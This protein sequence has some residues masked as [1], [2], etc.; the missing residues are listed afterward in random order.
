M[1]NSSCLQCAYTCWC[2]CLLTSVE[3]RGNFKDLSQST[4]TLIFSGDRISHWMGSLLTWLGWPT[5]ELLQPFSLYSFSAGVT[6]LG[7]LMWV[8]RIG[9][10]VLLLEWQY[11]TDWAIFLATVRALKC[12]KLQILLRVISY[13]SW[14][15]AIW[16]ITQPLS[17]HSCFKSCGHVQWNLLY[18]WGSFT[19]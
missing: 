13:S 4:L 19:L 3:I 9:T 8:P 7:H 18:S 6:V 11:F 14:A 2:K 5:N 1:H 16:I 15:I 12:G 10:H 17:G